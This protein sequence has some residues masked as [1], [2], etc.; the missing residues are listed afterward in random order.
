M[1]CLCRQAPQCEHAFCSACIQEWLTRQPT[2]PVDRSPITPSQLKQVPRILRNLLSRLSIT[3]D[4]ASYGCPAVVKLDTLHAHLQEC[5]HN[6][7]KPVHCEMG[8]GL[9]IPKDELKVRMHNPKKLIQCEMW[10]RL[11]ISE[12]VVKG[13]EETCTL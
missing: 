4:N 5:D 1:L 13:Y 11:V 2:C 6:P 7:K 12:Y 3:C 10:Y 9:V 8:C